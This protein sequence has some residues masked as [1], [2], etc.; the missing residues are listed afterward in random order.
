VTKNWATLFLENIKRI[1]KTA[2]CT[3]IS[4]ALEWL[5]PIL[6]AGPCQPEGPLLFDI[7][8]PTHHSKH[9]WGINLFGHKRPRLVLGLAT[10]WVQQFAESQVQDQL[11]QWAEQDRLIWNGGITWSNGQWYLKLYATGAP[12]TLPKEYQQLPGIMGVG[13]DVHRHAITRL[14]SYRSAEENQ[15]RSWPFINPIPDAKEI[16][17]QLITISRNNA[18][19]EKRSQNF[20]LQPWAKQERIVTLSKAIGFTQFEVEYDFWRSLL[21]CDGI[22]TSVVAF[23]W[24]MYDDN[25]QEWDYLLSFRYPC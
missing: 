6:I 19:P 9:R 13:F 3:D 1:A 15:D 5:N 21:R 10:K 22:E 17:H 7:V 25:N 2:D 4:P 11:K 20:I 16:A 14:R 24:D 12:D 23:E 18:Q 8:T